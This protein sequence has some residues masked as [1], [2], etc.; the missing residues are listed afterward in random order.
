VGS[1]ATSM[2]SGS[3]AY[4]RASGGGRTQVERS[5]VNQRAT[6]MPVAQSQFSSRVSQSGYQQNLSNLQQS[7]QTNQVSANAGVQRGPYIPSVSISVVF[8]CNL[9]IHVVLTTFHIQLVA[10]FILITLE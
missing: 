6:A 1:T 10:V 9:Y 5:V 3:S 7:S 8:I 2:N 4:D